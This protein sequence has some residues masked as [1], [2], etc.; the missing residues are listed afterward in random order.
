MKSEYSI[1]PVKKMILEKQLEKFLSRHGIKGVKQKAKKIIKEF[2]D[3]IKKILN[4]HEA[5]G[6]VKFLLAM[7]KQARRDSKLQYYIKDLLKK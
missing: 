1:H 3:G 6:H 5:E 4:E 2:D 7:Q